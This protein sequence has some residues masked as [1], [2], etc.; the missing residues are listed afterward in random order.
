VSGSLLW[1]T[2]SR[3]D[4]NRSHEFLCDPWL[5]SAR[6]SADRAELS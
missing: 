2:A 6:E 5:L 4:S 3:S 1:I